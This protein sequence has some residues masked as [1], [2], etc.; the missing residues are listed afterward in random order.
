MVPHQQRK[1]IVVLVPT[2][3]K[4]EFGQSVEELGEILLIPI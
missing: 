3:F 2:A 4:L 1:G